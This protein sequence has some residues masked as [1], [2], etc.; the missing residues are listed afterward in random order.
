M[1]WRSN[2]IPRVAWL[3]YMAG[4]ESQLRDQ[5]MMKARSSNAGRKDSVHLARLFNG[6]Y[7]YWLKKLREERAKA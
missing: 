7:V 4:R 3:A 6:M 2:D 5:W 1:N